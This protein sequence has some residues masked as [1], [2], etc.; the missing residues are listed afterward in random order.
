MNRLREGLLCVGMYTVAC[1]AV[2]AIYTVVFGRSM[3]DLLKGQGFSFKK[4][5]TASFGQPKDKLYV[6][7]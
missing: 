5:L 2:V 7:R 1:G 3:R 6:R 4:H